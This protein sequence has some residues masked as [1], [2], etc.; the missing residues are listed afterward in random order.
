LAESDYDEHADCVLGRGPGVRNSDCQVCILDFEADDETV[1]HNT[2]QNTFHKECFDRWSRTKKEDGDPVTCPKCRAEL[3]EGDEVEEGSDGS[4]PETEDAE[5][6]TSS[7][8]VHFASWDDD[9]NQDNPIQGL[10]LI[11][12]IRNL[13]DM[14]T[15]NNPRMEARRATSD[16]HVYEIPLDTYHRAIV[17]E[18]PRRRNMPAVQDGH[19]GAWSVDQLYMDDQYFARFVQQGIDWEVDEYQVYWAPPFVRRVD[20]FLIPVYDAYHAG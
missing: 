5:N 14:R 6:D 19:P 20:F 15:Y 12:Y 11:G 10:I 17:Q 8:S 9:A 4:E 2:C 18:L 13:A 3:V 1:T 7:T 16:G